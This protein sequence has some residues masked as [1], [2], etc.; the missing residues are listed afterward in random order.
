MSISIMLGFFIKGKIISYKSPA[1]FFHVVLKMTQFLFE[2]TL[3]YNSYGYSVIFFTGSANIY[4]IP[5]VLSLRLYT[6][7]E[8]TTESGQIMFL[9]KEEMATHSSILA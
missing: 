2:V 5:N 7:V 8:I 1:L 6:N 4:S 9:L 3:I